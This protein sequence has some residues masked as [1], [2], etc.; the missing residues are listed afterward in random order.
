MSEGKVGEERERMGKVGGNR[1]IDR[2]TGKRIDRQ[3]GRQ[4]G[5]HV[6]RYRLPPKENAFTK[7][8]IETK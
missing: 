3:V 7:N 6:D 5:K 2:Q 8:E 1:H 4:T